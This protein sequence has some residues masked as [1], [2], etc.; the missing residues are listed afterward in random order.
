MPVG[1]ISKVCKNYKKI[2]MMK[3]TYKKI[4]L[5]VQNVPRRE[6]FKSARDVLGLSLPYY[7][8]AINRTRFDE[9]W[10]IGKMYFKLVILILFLEKYLCFER[11][12]LSQPSQCYKYNTIA[13]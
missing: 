10:R 7:C 2:I 12:F 3:N 9:L 1:K 11:Y 8:K 6:D 4:F 13:R 5:N